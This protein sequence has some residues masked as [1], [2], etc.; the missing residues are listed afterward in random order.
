MLDVFLFRLTEEVRSDLAVPI[1]CMRPSLS[2][3]LRTLCL[4][5][6]Y[7]ERLPKNTGRIESAQDVVECLCFDAPLLE[8]LP[9]NM[10]PVE[11]AQDIVECLRF[12]S[13]SVHARCS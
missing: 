2:F 12:R 6:P 10:G 11:S 7:P 4:D 3:S 9:K 1:S 13:H 8:R 5:A